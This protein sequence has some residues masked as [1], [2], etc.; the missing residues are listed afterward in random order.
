MHR[1]K[2]KA[3]PSQTV[4]KSH[5]APQNHRKAAAPA[6]VPHPTTDPAAPPRM[7]ARRHVLDGQRGSAGRHYGA[8]LGKD[9]GAADLCMTVLV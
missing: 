9:A 8:G 1:V 4:P 6:R 2:I 3:E 7:E 5:R